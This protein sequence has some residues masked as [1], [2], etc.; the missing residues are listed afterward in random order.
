AINILDAKIN[1]RIE[2]NR[3]IEDITLNS[4]ESEIISV[5][6]VLINNSND[7]FIRNSIKNPKISISIRKEESNCII[8]ISDNAQGIEKEIINRIFEPYFT[9]KDKYHGTG[10][11]LY[12]L[13]NLLTRQLQGDIKV[14]NINCEEPDDEKCGASFK[15]TIPI[16]I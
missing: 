3:N 14:E 11:G 7:A 8:I 4:Y 13:Q 1:K 5:L 2:F 9:T 15:L 6:L 12:M 16:N 10:L